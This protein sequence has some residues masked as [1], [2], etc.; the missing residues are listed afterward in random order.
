MFKTKFN[1]HKKTM[2]KIKILYTLIFIFYES[3]QEDEKILDQMVA[4]IPWIYS[5]LNSFMHTAVLGVVAKYLNCATVSDIYF[6][7]V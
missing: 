2:G 6:S 7:Y 3:E 4:G 1:T 5:T